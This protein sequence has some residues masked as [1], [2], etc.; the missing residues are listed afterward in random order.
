MTPARTAAESAETPHPKPSDRD[1]MV[2]NGVGASGSFP[3]SGDSRPTIEQR[4]EIETT[5]VG[6]GLEDDEIGVPIGLHDRYVLRKLIGRG[7]MGAVFL[8]EDAELQRKVAIKVV[9]RKIESARQSLRLRREARALASID[10]ENVL[11]VFDLGSDGEE[12]FFAME[13]VAGENLRRWQDGRSVDELFGAY[14]QAGRG[15]AAAHAEGLVHRDFK[16]DNVLVD[17]Q[18]GLRVRVGDFGLVGAEIDGRTLSDV[19][20]LRGLRTSTHALLGTVPYMAPEQL[21]RKPADVRSDQHQFCVALWEA[22]AGARPFGSRGRP[23]EGDTSVPARPASMPRWIYPVLRKGLAFVGEERHRDMNA[24]LAALRSARR[25]WRVLQWSAALGLVA[26][27]ALL[28][29]WMQPEPCQDTDQRIASVW[30]P[31]IRARITGAYEGEDGQYIAN[32]LDGAAAQWSEGSYGLCMA[33]RSAALSEEPKLEDRRAC[34]EQRAYTMEQRITTLLQPDFSDGSAAVDLVAELDDAIPCE[35]AP[36]PIDA[37]VAEAIERAE[38]AELLR[39]LDDALKL[40][41]DAVSLA[42]D[43]TKRN[44]NDVRCKGDTG[45][46]VSSELAAAKFRLG[47]IQSERNEEESAHRSLYE[48][49]LNA[50]VCGDEYRDAE[51]RIHLAKLLALDLQ[52]VEGARDELFQ[53]RVALRRAEAPSESLWYYDERMAAAIIAETAQDY[54]VA[55]KYAR[56]G[57]AALGE[58]ADPVLRAKLEINI[59]STLHRQRRYRDAAKAYDVATALVTDALGGSHPRSGLYASKRALN[60]GIAAQEEGE[61]ATMREHFEEAVRFDEPNI[62]VKALTAWIQGDVAE[63]Q[64]DEDKEAVKSKAMKLLGILE[65]HGQT[66]AEIPHATAELTVGQILVW[67]ND[68]KGEEVVAKACER[69]ADLDAEYPETC[70]QRLTEARR[71]GSESPQ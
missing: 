64:T 22:M 21:Q 50:Y 40:A 34:L 33:T 66:I 49:H 12:L 59:G 11:K 60:L 32:A 57:I 5:L 51:A 19:T 13:H 31:E 29:W 65:K 25:W 18:N 46:T 62:R 52:D 54:D 10:H 41:E 48:A 26:C 3:H 6:L 37:S 53:A 70:R 61:F 16:P 24:L 9:A 67:L 45:S 44:G 68:P 39:E 7:S 71:T 55:R 30:T 38:Q 35:I 63:A 43:W 69:W 1:G 47:H 27:V 28:G 2:G 8:A 56:E 4:Y 15:L 23:V 17:E 20:T 36:T 58:A 42:R 14:I